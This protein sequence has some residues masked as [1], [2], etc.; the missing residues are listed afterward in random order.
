[1]Q[2][3]KIDK[4][5]FDKIRALS[6][7]ARQFLQENPESDAKVQFNFPH[8]VMVIGVMSDA[9]TAK[10]ISYNDD[11]KRMLE[12]MGAFKEGQDQ[13]TVF[14][15]RAAIEYMSEIEKEEKEDKPRLREPIRMVNTCPYCEAVLDGI[16]GLTRKERQPEPGDVSMCCDCGNVAIFGDDMKLRVLDKSD[17]E[18]LGADWEKIEKAS[19]ML[20]QEIHK[21]ERS[22]HGGRR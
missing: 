14:M 7:K 13:P 17:M 15:V 22:K 10:F 11:G 19:E 16:S 2:Y 20:K 21:R 6:R 12:A 3:D 8:D 18:K 9:K 4:E 5:Y 1:M